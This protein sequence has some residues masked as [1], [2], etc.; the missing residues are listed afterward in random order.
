[1]KTI[2][3]IGQQEALLNP[4]SRGQKPSRLPVWLQKTMVIIF[5]L[6]IIASGI[7]ALTE[8]WRRASLMLGLALAWLII[9]RITCD[10][11]IIGL[12]SVRSKRFDVTFCLGIAIA[13]VGLAGS[14]DSLGS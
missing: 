2:E 4:H 7:W 3:P 5:L 14:V 6:M 1:M 13:M 9:P 10:D 8:H 12:F 11:R